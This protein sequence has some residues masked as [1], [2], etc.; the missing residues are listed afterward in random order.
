MEI[1]FEKVLLP[2]NV[3]GLRNLRK[4]LDI[5]TKLFKT[6]LHAIQNSPT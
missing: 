3:K 6:P 4:L 2:Q 5:S 1:I